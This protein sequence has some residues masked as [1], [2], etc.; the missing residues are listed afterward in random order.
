MKLYKFLLISDELINNPSLFDSGVKD[1]RENK[2]LDPD[3][4]N[5]F[6]TYHE[7]EELVFMGFKYPNLG[8]YETA[9]IL[10]DRDMV[11]KII[12]DIK[13]NNYHWNSSNDTEG[14]KQPD[15]EATE[16]LLKALRKF[17]VYGEDEKLPADMIQ[18]H[19]IR[20]GGYVTSGHHKIHEYVLGVS[21]SAK[22]KYAHHKGHTFDNRKK[23]LDLVSISDHNNIH[24][25][26]EFQ[27]DIRRTKAVM[28]GDFYSTGL[29]CTCGE[30]DSNIKK[31][32][33]KNCGAILLINQEQKLTEFIAQLDSNEYTRLA[34]RYVYKNI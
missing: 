14:S 23:F 2:V 1:L 16:R 17:E 15:I 24:D 30:P 34:D 25:Q 10:I 3:Y 31:H 21:D 13:K 33:C 27:N 6:Y 4:I 5:R 12:Y 32:D 26:W 29:Q 7:N 20:T 28:I 18:R 19:K 8:E 11:N 22:L 9:Y